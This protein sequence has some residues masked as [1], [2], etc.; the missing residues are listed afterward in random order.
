MQKSSILVLGGDH[1]QTC[2]SKHSVVYKAHN[3]MILGVYALIIALAVATVAATNLQSVAVFAITALVLPAFVD[4]IAIPVVILDQSLL[5]AATPPSTFEKQVS[6]PLG[7]SIDLA[8]LVVYSDHTPIAD[9]PV[10][11]MGSQTQPSYVSS[12][13]G[14]NFHQTIAII[15]CLVS[16]SVACLLIRSWRKYYPDPGPGS[17]RQPRISFAV[18]SMSS[19]TSVNK[20]VDLPVEVSRNLGSTPVAVTE[21]SIAYLPGEGDI[22]SYGVEVAVPN[23]D[24]VYHMSVGAAT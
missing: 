3:V 10:N 1:T 7:L 11:T 17:R 15:G 20:R 5:D 18:S 4:A 2:D 21:P 16:L 13:S 8:T 22:V 24:V 14:T 19:A 12:G 6:Q 9:Q 23:Q